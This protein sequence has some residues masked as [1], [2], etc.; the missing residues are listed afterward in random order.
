MGSLA[1]QIFVIA[2]L[3]LFVVA[4]ALAFGVR[5]GWTMEVCAYDREQFIAGLALRYGEVDIGGGQSGPNAILRI[6]AS[7]QTGTFSI[8]K[9]GTDGSVCMIA[10]GTDLELIA[11]TLPNPDEKES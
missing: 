10:I 11:P 5:A 4:A 6:Y 7:P 8:L 1:R 3:H 2:A 9:F